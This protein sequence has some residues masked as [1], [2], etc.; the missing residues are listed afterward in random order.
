VD[1]FASYRFR[2]DV[3]GA[4]IAEFSECTGM[5]LTVKYDEVR[6]GGQN[7]FVHRLPGRV[8]YGNLILRRGYATSNEF[9]D[10]FKSVFNRS[11]IQRRNVTVMLVS[12]SGETVTQ[13]TFVDAYPVKWSG[14]AFKA[15]DNAI[16]VESV[17]LAHRGLLG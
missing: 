12:Q 9:F 1:P 8:E 11:S 16:A 3:D 17:E 7:E 2:V 13:W 4:S 10:W 14:P 6:E 5:E 15:G